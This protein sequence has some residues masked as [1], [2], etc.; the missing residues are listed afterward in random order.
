LFH[1]LRVLEREKKC[2]SLWFHDGLNNDI[3]KYRDAPCFG[4]Q[5]LESLASSGSCAGLIVMDRLI[6][7]CIG[8]TSLVFSA[9]LWTT[10]RR[11]RSL[12]HAAS[13]RPPAMLFTSAL[14]TKTQN[15]MTLRRVIH[16]LLNIEDEVRMQQDGVGERSDLMDRARLPSVQLS[17]T[18]NSR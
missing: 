8:E 7:Q 4:R 12:E 9:T 10:L 13:P 1:T 5:R 14:S 17:F 18:G 3:R 6:C 15:L 16:L 2:F 11:S